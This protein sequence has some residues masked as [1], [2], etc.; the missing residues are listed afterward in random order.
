MYFRKFILLFTFVQLLGFF[1]TI[2]IYAQN[3]FEA[4]LTKKIQSF[5]ASNKTAQL[6]P[7]DAATGLLIP[8]GWGGYG[9]Y[10]YGSLGGAFPEVYTND[11]L[12]LV[13]SGG[14]SIGNPEKF[15]NFAAGLNVQ[16]VSSFN[17]FTFD[18]TISRSL[19]K[20]SSI[21]VGGMQLFALK[22]KSDAPEPTFY[23][24]VSHSLQTLPSKSPGSSRLTYTIGLG[25]GRFLLKSPIDKMNNRGNYGTA[26]FGGISY[27]I[28]RHINLNAEWTGLNLGISLGIAPFRKMPVSIA[29]GVA[30]LTR[31]SSDKPNIIFALGFPLSLNRNK[32]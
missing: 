31:Y 13:A 21:S 1:Y 27:E 19:G 17:N 24:A 5:S 9:T 18:L 10:L 26:V 8:S 7:N 30:E 6:Y 25:S 15:L 20:G 2:P 22:I 29:I 28:L 14:V 3:S 12:D 4:A 16:D 32:F 11:F 23:V